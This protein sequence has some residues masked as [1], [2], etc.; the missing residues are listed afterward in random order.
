MTSRRSDAAAAGALLVAYDIV[1]DKRRGRVAKALEK[2]GLRVQFSVFLLR[3]KTP[4]DVRAALAPL[5]VPKEDN[6]R[7]HVLCAS[8]EG[9]VLLLGRAQVDNQPV[10]FRV[11]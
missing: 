6:V 3:R 7:I 2:L 4:E 1:D 9:K 5:I 8:C 11:V 10:G